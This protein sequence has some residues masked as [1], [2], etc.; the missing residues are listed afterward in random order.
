MSDYD[1]RIAL[2]RQ[3]VVLQKLD[4]CRW[5]R[6]RWQVPLPGARYKRHGRIEDQS[7]CDLGGV[8][9]QVTDREIQLDVLSSILVGEDRA[10][11]Q[12]AEPAS[13]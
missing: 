2:T 11:L 6:A 4:Q 9:S 3:V 12:I 8:S 7:Q 5:H 10:A 13:E 1:F